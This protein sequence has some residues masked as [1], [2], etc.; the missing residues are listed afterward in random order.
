MS[1]LE[2]VISAN[3]RYAADFGDKGKLT[4]P[5]ARHFRDPHLHGRQA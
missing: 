4:I 3:D 2:E 1:I 5:P